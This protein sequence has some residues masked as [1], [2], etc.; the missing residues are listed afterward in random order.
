MEESLQRMKTDHVDLLQLHNP[1]VEDVEDG[2]LVEVL[3]EIRQRAR[4]GLSV[5][6]LTRPIY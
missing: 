2:G 4:L 5:S 1:T 3:R 6:L